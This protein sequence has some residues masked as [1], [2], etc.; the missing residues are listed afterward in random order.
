VNLV[1]G[2]S[3][4]VKI[5]GDSYSFDI[6]ETKYDNQITLSPTNKGQGVKLKHYVRNKK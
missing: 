2:K 5:Q 6:V 3:L 4:P 1:V